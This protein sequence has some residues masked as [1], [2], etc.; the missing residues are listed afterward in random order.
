MVKSVSHPTQNGFSSPC[1]RYLWVRAVCPMRNRV[2]MTSSL[3]ERSEGFRCFSLGFISCNLLFSCFSQWL[4]HR[5]EVYL[6]TL[7]LKSVCGRV[8]VVD[9]N[10][11]DKDSFARRSTCSFPRMPTWLGSHANTMFLPVSVKACI[12]CCNLTIFGCKSV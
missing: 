6:L 8:F 7:F 10:R 9:P 3:L 5:L 2:K 12:F 1:R 4:S 11:R